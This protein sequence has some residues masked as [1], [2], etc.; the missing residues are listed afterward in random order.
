MTGRRGPLSGVRLIEMAGIGPAPMCGM[1]LSDLG[2]DIL[3]IDRPTPSDVGIKRPVETNFILRGRRTIP[4]DLKTEA[5]RA[6][7]LRLLREADGVF[8]GFRPG[9]MERLGL[10]PE[11][12]LAANPALVYGRVT[13][14]GQSGPMAQTAGHDLTYLALTGA[15]GAMGRQGE[16]PPVPL[17]LVGD[18]AG[19][20]LFLAVG[21]LSALI[22]ARE[23]GRGQVVDAAIVDGVASML[24]SINGLRQAGIFTPEPG[25]NIL[26]GGAYFY[27]VY[28]CADGGAIAV[29]PIEKKFFAQFVERLGIDP[30][31]LPPQDDA[32]RWPEGRAVLADIFAGRDRDAWAALF[33]GTDA[34]VVPVLSIEESFRDPHLAA[35]GTYQQID[36]RPQAAPAPRFSDTPP[37]TPAPPSIASTEDALADW[38][39]PE[40]IRSL[41][42]GASN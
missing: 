17:N 26:D 29:G 2:A 25:T 34:C 6:L 42:S 1:V 30:A 19:G 36:G 33:A 7:V 20:A 3:R 21:M 23:S 24:S 28:R 5:G 37:A 13:G 39:P 15:L 4:V 8:E 14:W 31:T 9:V 35:R 18:F 12:A 22:A 32:A 38:L 41:L 40:E 16:L 11:A 10:G 27:D